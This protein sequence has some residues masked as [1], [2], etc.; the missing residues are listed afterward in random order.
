MQ[1]WK[2]TEGTPQGGVISP[3][4]ANIVLNYLDWGTGLDGEKYTAAGSRLFPTL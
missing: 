4:L 2:P 1:E 3:L